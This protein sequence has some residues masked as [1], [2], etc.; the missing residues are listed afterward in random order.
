MLSYGITANVLF[1]SKI[2][3]LAM[4]FKKC[5]IMG[6]VLLFEKSQWGGPFLLLKYSTQICVACW[7]WN[8]MCVWGGPAGQFSWMLLGIKTSLNAVVYAQHGIMF[9]LRTHRRATLPFVLYKERGMASMQTL[10][11]GAIP[12]HASS[13]V[14]LGSVAHCCQDYA[15]MYSQEP[16]YMYF[17]SPPLLIYANLHMWHQ[18]IIQFMA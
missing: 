9:Q 14:R 2:W 6:Q 18:L 5:S 7:W 13:T 1:I 11:M 4:L 3:F 10:K 15:S 16:V 12:I 8:T 17:F